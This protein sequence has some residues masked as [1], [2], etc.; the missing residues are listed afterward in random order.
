MAGETGVEERRLFDHVKTKAET[1][2]TLWQDLSDYLKPRSSA[3]LE[4]K[5]ADVEGWTDNIYNN[6][7]V[8]ANRTSAA[9]ALD[10]LF[11]GEFFQFDP[12]PELKGNQRAMRWYREAAEQSRYDLANSNFGTTVHERLLDRG[13]F[14]VCHMA[15]EPGKRNFLNFSGAS[16]GS[17]YCEK[18]KEGYVDSVWI[19]WDDMTACQIVEEF[20]DGKDLSG[21][22][23]EVITDYNDPEKQY[24]VH[25]V[26][27]R[28][29]PRK[30]AE[31]N[32][33]ER[34][35]DKPIASV[36]THFKSKKILRNSGYDEMTDFVSR[37]LTWGKEVYGYCPGIEVLPTA[38]Q[39]NFIEM[40][41]DA[42]AEIKV[43]PRMLWPHD[44]SGS[45]QLHA[46]GVTFVDPNNVAKNDIPREWLTGGDLRDMKERLLM[47][48]DAINRAYHVDL[49]RALADR[50][51]QMTAT[52][53]AE[54]VA[55]KLINFSPTYGQITTELST[56]TLKRVFSMS[57]EAGRYGE[58]PPEIVEWD[59]RSPYADIRAPRIVY[60]SK[61]ALALKA[62]Q[63]RNFVEYM[64]IMGPIFEK[65]PGTAVHMN[66]DGVAK[67]VA[68]NV[69]L[70]VE[71]LNTEEVV[72]QLK[73]E[74]RQ[75]QQA[76]MTSEAAA[77]GAKAAK[78]IS[79]VDPQK[80]EQLADSVAQ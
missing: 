77:K 36:Y 72:A 34:P 75:M 20:T 46:G 54:L 51:K 29:S 73:E 19:D 33:T 22:P 15:V 50:H 61:V 5:T 52:E 10:Y 59:G 53:V 79:D 9:G 43:F 47:K 11:T 7:A 40:L 60:T 71:M 17:F 35:E 6:D 78:D 13:A 70:P 26:I 74:E 66:W 37:Y 55:E 27:Q 56:P 38:K 30:P 58:P 8:F 14:G 25:P 31:M 32:G 2:R 64:Q 48:R 65:I 4:R 45:I 44:M 28:I 21:L 67:R 76:A 68:D 80:I 41:M 1:W 23:K 57:L 42:E 16:V 39:L 24:N 69:G 63:N 12:P 49:F 3:I 62:L 18:D